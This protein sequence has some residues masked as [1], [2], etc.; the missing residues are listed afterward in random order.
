M[1]GCVA[2]WGLFVSWL[3]VM[4]AFAISLMYEHRNPSFAHVTHIN[5]N[6]AKSFSSQQYISKWRHR[7]RSPLDEG[8]ITELRMWTF[9]C[10]NNGTQNVD[11][12]LSLQNFHHF[13]D[14]F[15]ARGRERKYIYENMQRLRHRSSLLNMHISKRSLHP[16][17]HG[18][19][20][21]ALCPSPPTAARHSGQ[22]AT[23][24][25]IPHSPIVNGC[26]FAQRY[27]CPDPR[28]STFMALY[29]A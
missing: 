15:V 11:L 5:V 7:C 26:P 23:S 13:G 20:L 29:T 4:R 19:P 6:R 3:Q 8:K 14:F 27:Q 18:N 21:T 28:N 17:I 25:G 2:K 24:I 9:P 16:L 1:G 22:V 12:P 10:E